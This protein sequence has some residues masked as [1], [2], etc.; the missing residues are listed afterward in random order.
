MWQLANFDRDDFL[1]NYWQKRPLLIRQALPGF[2]SPLSPEELAGLACEPGVHSR[3]VVE[4][5]GDEPWQ[6]RY[7]PFN[8]EDF[9]SLP[10]THY[11]LLVS[12]CE[13]WV[14]E[15]R[16]LVDC[17]TFVPR[18]RIDDL[19]ISYAPEHGSVG[20]HTDE[21]DVFLVQGAG[22]RRWS[23]ENEISTNPPLIPGLDLA[24]LQE[25]NADESWLL[26]PGDM[27]YLPP[28]IAH[29]GVAVGTGCMTYSI[30]FRAPTLGQTMDSLLLQASDRGLTDLR[31]EDP[32]LD[33]A[34]NPA[35]I[36]VAAISQFK[37]QLF[38]ML[39]QLDSDWPDIIGKLVSDADL[40][41][42][43]PA[44]KCESSAEARQ[45]AWQ[46][47]PDS[48]MF[49]YRDPRKLH[50]YC[51]GKAFNLPLDDASCLQ[52]CDQ[53]GNQGF[54]ERHHPAWQESSAAAG[55][56]LSLIDSAALIPDDPDGD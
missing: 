53:L 26:A 42:D 15:L 20:P 36:S 35:A 21:Y 27:L 31:Y 39:E 56:L 18:W 6:L 24:I 32:S 17:F 37:A 41:D 46:K 12:E 44:L 13:K 5:D 1:A 34:A 43:I 45:L 19:M 14:P 29:H 7:G 4:K 38:D 9:T 25:F 47:H 22:Q 55:L 51:N 49:F 8:E 30:G 40:A 16:A 50:F 33:A 23:I 54:I 10:Q 28:K 52:L 3:L 11:S 2:S 48:R